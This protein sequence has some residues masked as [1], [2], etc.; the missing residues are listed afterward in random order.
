M[1][2]R[3]DNDEIKKAALAGMFRVNL[4]FY[5]NRE[6]ASSVQYNIDFAQIKTARSRRNASLAKISEGTQENPVKKGRKKKIHKRFLQSLPLQKTL[7]FRVNFRMQ[8]L[9]LPI[10]S[11]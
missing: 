8:Y 1:W 2:I 6:T 3:I 10:V 4:A 11:N 7:Q 9:V 5:K